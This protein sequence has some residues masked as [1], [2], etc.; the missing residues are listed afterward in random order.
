MCLLQ[1]ISIL[2]PRIQTGS[3]KKTTIKRGASIGAGSTIGCCITIGENAM[4]G[5]ESVVIHNV[6]VGEVWVGYPAR[7]MKMTNDYE[8]KNCRDTISVDSNGRCTTM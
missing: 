5:M 6:P 3:W 2:V 8:A 7:F 1:T 4:I